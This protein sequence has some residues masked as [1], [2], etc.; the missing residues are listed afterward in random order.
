MVGATSGIGRAVALLFASKGYRVGA[1]GRREELLKSLQQHYPERIEVLPFDITQTELL[2]DKFDTLAKRV[3]EVELFIH[4]SGTGRRNLE[5]ELQ[6]ELSVVMLNGVA[7]TTS[8]NWAYHHFK[9]RGE[10]TI[11]A[12]TSIA[13]MRGFGLSPSYSGTKSYQI[14]Y[15]ESL[16]QLVRGEGSGLTIIDIRAGFVDTAMGRGKGAFWQATPERAAEGIYRAVVKK[17]KVAYVTKR[18]RV[19]SWLLKVI[20]RGLFVN[21]KWLITIEKEG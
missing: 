11:A 8:L 4:S 6:Q 5:L 21:L 3:G 9:E 20:P 19:V 18:W 16:Q 12:V 17:R 10:G 7:F 15:L 1:V 13:G 14:T 2:I